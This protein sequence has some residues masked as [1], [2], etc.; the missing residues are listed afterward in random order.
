MKKRALILCGG[1]GLRLRPITEEIP[2]PM[3][4]I[5]N[6]SIL[7]YIIDH[8]CTFNFDEIVIAT[9]YRSNK[10]EEYLVN[11]YPN[12]EFKIFNSGYVDIIQ[13]IKD[14]SKNIKG[15]LIVLYGDTLSDVDINE[16]I[17]FHHSQPGKATITVWPLQSQFG[18]LDV[19][20]YGMI[21]SYKEKPIF[22]KW[23]NIGYFY[24]ENEILQLLNEFDDF[25]AYLS[26]LVEWRE[27]NGYKHLGSHITVNTLKELEYAENNINKMTDM[28]KG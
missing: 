27:L 2:K 18:V 14:V 22:D 21:A 9:G 12:Y 11:D 26:Q 24:F 28:M 15:D 3:V 1:E 25:S 13:R 6:K 17:K 8:I 4:K 23:I 20:Q 10:I 7:G 16:L 5:N 19:D